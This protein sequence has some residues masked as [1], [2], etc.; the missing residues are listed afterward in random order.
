MHPLV[1]NEN[2]LLIKEPSEDYEV[3]TLDLINKGESSRCEFKSTIRVNLHTNGPDPK[4]EMQCMKTIGAFLNTKDGTLLIGVADD[5]EVLGLESDFNSFKKEDKLDE[6]QKHL[7][8]LVEQHFNNSV[9]SLITVSFP[10]VNEKKICRV[11]VSI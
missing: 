9:F 1:D 2:K 7:D 10:E 6:F 11:D 5:K 8:N 3:S 4:I